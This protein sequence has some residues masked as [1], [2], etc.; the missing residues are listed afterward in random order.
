MRTDFTFPRI[1]K[2]AIGESDTAKPPENSE[3]RDKRL[4]R[5]SA[6]Q[7]AGKSQHAVRSRKSRMSP[8]STPFVNPSGRGTSTDWRLTL[9][10]NVSAAASIGAH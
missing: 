7:A 8:L 3:V 1:Q 4:V 10:W 5:F 2:C 9:N 6:R